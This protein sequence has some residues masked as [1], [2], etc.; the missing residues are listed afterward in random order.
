MNRLNYHHLHYF[1]LV[2]RERSLARASALVRLAPSTLSG[3]IHAFERV[4]GQQLFARV[5]RRLELTDAGRLVFRYADDIFALGAELQDALQDHPAG[6]PVRVQVG[7][8]DAVPKM[9]ASLLLQPVLSMPERPVLSCVE[10]SPDRLLA[11]LTTHEVDVVLADAPCTAHPAIKVLSQLLMRCPVAIMGTTELAERYK[12]GFPRSLQGAPLL[13]PTPQANLH[14]SMEQWLS[15]NGLTPRIM[16]EFDDQALLIELGQA[17][18]G[19]F[20]I[21]AAIERAICSRYPVQRVGLVKEIHESFYA[22]TVERRVSH[23]AVMAIC[24]NHIH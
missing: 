8:V 9:V 14:R 20:P 22:I 11:C 21:P 3:Q 12:K 10:G 16:G 2:A 4:M 19:L 13:L 17:G 15:E 7:I 23:P 18:L 5:G 1:W 24:K 6:A